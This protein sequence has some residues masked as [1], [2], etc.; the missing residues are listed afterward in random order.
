MALADLPVGEDNID[1]VLHVIEDRPYPLPYPTYIKLVTKVALNPFIAPEK[2]E[3]ALYRIGR[4]HYF[5]SKEEEI[6]VSRAIEEI[7]L[8]TEGLIAQYALHYLGMGIAKERRS[9]AYVLEEIMLKQEGNPK[10]DNV[11]DMLFYLASQGSLVAIEMTQEIILSSKNR[12]DIIGGLHAL[13]E[14]SH[15][16]RPEL[17]VQVRDDKIVYAGIIELGMFGGELRHVCTA[18]YFEIDNPEACRPK[19]TLRAIQALKEIFLK[20]EDNFIKAEVRKILAGAA[21]RNIPTAKE[22]LEEIKKRR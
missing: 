7:Y 9:S 21:Q 17:E 4:K 3:R 16:Y 1:R 6:A 18:N 12:L 2:R 19:G 15:H 20:S 22:A 10:R 13:A 5:S 14:A 11:R 8:N